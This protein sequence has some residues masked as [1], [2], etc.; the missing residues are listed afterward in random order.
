MKGYGIDLLLSK[1]SGVEKSENG[2]R[3]RCPACGGNS[4]KLSV[5]ERNG[6]VLI[7]CF[8]CGDAEAILSA[9]GLSWRDMRPPRSRPESKEEQARRIQSMRACSFSQAVETMA[10][11]SKVVAIAANELL[12][13][14]KAVLSK[15]DQV[16][17]QQ[18]I[19]RIDRVANMYVDTKRW[20][21]ALVKAA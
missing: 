16:R 15:D 9:V 6:V 18:A 11:E 1:L 12:R 21:P 20:R 13:Y 2:W 7:N 17:L 10:L 19:E 8:A 3:A 5:T 14:S 4:R